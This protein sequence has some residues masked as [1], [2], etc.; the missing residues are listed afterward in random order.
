[1]SCYPER[2]SQIKDKVKVALDLPIY[3]TKKNKKMLLVLI[4]LI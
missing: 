3:A 1:M 2:D 4:D